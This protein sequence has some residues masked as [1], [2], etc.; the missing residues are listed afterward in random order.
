[1]STDDH[2]SSDDAQKEPRPITIEELR[3]RAICKKRYGRATLTIGRWGSYGGLME[4]SDLARKLKS[5]R[6]GETTAEDVAWAF[7]RDRV[8]SHS[9]TFSWKDAD[10]KRLI[11]LVTDC[12]QSPH[13]K[14]QSADELAT[15]LIKAQDNEREQ[16][17]RMSAQF[18]KSFAGIGSLSKAF[19]PQIGQWAV[20]QEK[21]FAGLSRS[22]ISPQ[23]SEQ[24]SGFATPSLHQQMRSLGL[25]ASVRKQMLPTLQKGI[26]DGLAKQIQTIG[27]SP[28]M[29]KQ[30]LGLQPGIADSLTS[31]MRTQ[32]LLAQHIRLPDTIYGGLAK[33]LQHSL[34]TYRTATLTP[35]LE[36]LSRHQ[37]F[38]IGEVVSAAREASKLAEEHG[39]REEAR[40]LA[41]LTAD[42]VEVVESPSVERLEQMVG[43]L[44]EHLSERLDRI[45]EQQSATED[46][47]QEDRRDDM[48]LNLFLWFLAT[49][50]AFFL[51]ILDQTQQ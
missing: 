31:T 33:S 47:R 41:T 38:S 8:E 4:Q 25:T 7:V 27:L 15:E 17:R 36:G 51:W 50:L 18:A 5:F 35:A 10:L 1:M 44:S 9:P 46:K 21:L 37:S 23:L 12:S 11:H 24:L 29:R 39:E 43:D 45:R 16:L 13:F 49:Y 20:Q 30:I 22:F 40:T 32:T 28:G 6:A 19:Q 14:T 26:A 34:G 42:V 48:T 2:N 3:Q